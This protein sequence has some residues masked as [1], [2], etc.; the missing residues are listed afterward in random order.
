LAQEEARLLNH[1]FIGTEHLLLGLIR[2]GE[3]V[4]AQVLESIGVSLVAARDR[5]AE[6]VGRA[7]GPTIGSPPF[8]PRAKKVLELS[9]REALQLGHNYIGTEHLLLGLVR[10]GEG[11]AANVLVSLGAELP[12]VRRQ[13]ITSLRDVPAEAPGGGWV[14]SEDRRDGPRCPACRSLLEGH[15]AYRVLAVQPFE[16]GAA[17]QDVDMG[18]VYCMRCGVAIA[19]T[20]TGNLAGHL[21]FRVATASA[22]IANVFVPEQE[23]RL[24]ADGV[25]E[26]NVRWSLRVG[27]DDANYSTM[28]RIEDESGLISEGGMGGPKLWGSDLLNVYSGG[29]THRGPR[30]IVARCSPRV[31]HLILSYEDG[32]EAE[33]VPCGQGEIDGLRFG[34]LLIAPEARLRELIGIGQDGIIIDRFDLRGHDSSWHG[35]RKQ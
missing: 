32:T 17:S 1:N 20:D 28:L 33:L 35:H 15:V 26:G 18:F 7:A 8:T 23:S 6:S 21:P 10:E 29:D 30:A 5:I 25:A 27:G 31:E 9:L 12:Q 14:S 34:V 24:I 3:G 11:V 2:E 16:H 13:V 22:P 4:A 19:Q